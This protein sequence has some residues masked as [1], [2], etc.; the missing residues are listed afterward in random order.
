MR[1]CHSDSVPT[2]MQEYGPISLLSRAAYYTVTVPVTGGEEYPRCLVTVTEVFKF[3]LPQTHDAVPHIYPASPGPAGATKII[4]FSNRVAKHSRA[5]IVAVKGVYSHVL[6]AR[7]Y[8]PRPK[9]NA[10]LR[11]RGR[12]PRRNEES[13]KR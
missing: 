8:E 12:P 9:Q 13:N 7:T 1:V 11:L 2:A 10:Q 3:N 5:L 4:F 6:V